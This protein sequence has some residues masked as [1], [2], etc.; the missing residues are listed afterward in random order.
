MMTQASW[1]DEGTAAIAWTMSASL[2]DV[3]RSGEPV[4]EVTSLERAV[5]A[6]AE[7]DAEQRD[8]AILTTER[9]VTL[10]G[11]TPLDRFVGGAI[12]Q[13]VDLLPTHDRG[14]AR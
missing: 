7:L 8:A 4:P 9:P 3:S 10:P 2:E 14:E 5:R 6:W 13:F 11:E 12:G 1:S